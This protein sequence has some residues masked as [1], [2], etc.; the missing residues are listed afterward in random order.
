[1]RDGADAMSLVQPEFR[2]AEEL[3]RAL[4]AVGL[5]GLAV[6]L[7]APRVV[8]PP[9]PG[10]GEDRSALGRLLLRGQAG[11]VDAGRDWLDRLDQP[12][13]S[14]R[15]CLAVAEI[16]ATGERQLGGSLHFDKDLGATP[17]STVFRRFAV[18]FRPE[19][20]VRSAAT[21]T[22]P[23]EGSTYSFGEPD[24]LHGLLEA[25]IH[26]LLEDGRGR[27]LARPNLVLTTGVPA[28]LEVINEIP[29]LLL[30]RA[31]GDAVDIAQAPEKTGLLLQ[32][33]AVHVGVD[34]ATIDLDITLR[35]PVQ[36]EA[37]DM[38]PNTFELRERRVVTRL[39]LEDR[40]PLVFGG[41]VLK[42]RDRRRN[43]LPAAPAAL[44]P[45]FG[46]LA[47]QGLDREVWFV[48]TIAIDRPP[49]VS[50]GPTHHAR[51]REDRRLERLRAR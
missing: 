5:D 20:V 24:W 48:A 18:D 41:L 51:R 50:A 43:R 28:Q 31:T 45:L 29:R 23:F 14:L 6:D 9:L 42:G 21:R 44:D 38:A 47:F 49:L 16:A 11:P 19:A 32:A 35:V 36:V 10:Q 40:A 7:V 15:L 25:E 2:S 22:G 4:L 3:H 34:R 39:T 46:G 30:A 26:V 37:A 27:W 17:Q 1:V 8:L 13:R 12:D 33:T